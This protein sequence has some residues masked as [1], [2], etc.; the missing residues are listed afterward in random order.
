MSDFFHWVNERHLVSALTPDSGAPGLD[1]RAQLLQCL[2]D[3][4]LVQR[5]S[6]NR[7]LADWATSVLEEATCYTRPAL[8]RYVEGERFQSGVRTRELKQLGWDLLYVG[9][10]SPGTRPA[11][12]TQAGFLNS[13]NDTRLYAPRPVVATVIDILAKLWCVLRTQAGE[14]WVSAATSAESLAHGLIRAKEV[15]DAPLIRIVNSLLP[16]PSNS[17]PIETVLR[18]RENH[19][20]DLGQL[21]KAAPSGIRGECG[22]GWHISRR[23][24]EGLHARSSSLLR[25]DRSMA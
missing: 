10:L 17:V 12:T 11:L 3:I 24:H 5:E 1:V 4:A 19:S 7:D 25:G 13:E 8:L 16:V 21:S 23:C 18:F 22:A 9:K 6:N 14:T 15:P 20:N 2:R